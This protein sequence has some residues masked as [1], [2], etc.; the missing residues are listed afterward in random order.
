[1]PCTCCTHFS[2]WCWLLQYSVLESAGVAP[3]FCSPAVKRCSNWTI[4]CISSSISLF[5]I[6]RVGDEKWCLWCTEGAGYSVLGSW[7]PLLQV[8]LNFRV[9]E[10]DISN[11]IITTEMLEEN[12]MYDSP[13]WRLVKKERFQVNFCPL[14]SLLVELWLILF[15]KGFFQQ[16]RPKP[17]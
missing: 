16:N 15:E 4:Q 17:C 11:P 12:G 10:S 5:C 8:V 1:M 9:S 3:F 6:V 14:L 2:P 13:N 7:V